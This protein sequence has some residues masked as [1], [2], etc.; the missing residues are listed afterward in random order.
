MSRKPRDCL[1]DNGAADVL[2][3]R[4]LLLRWKPRACPQL[5]RPNT[6][7]QLGEQLVRQR[8]NPAAFFS[9]A[10]AG[11]L[12]RDPNSTCHTNLRKLR[13]RINI[14]DARHPALGQRERGSMRSARTSR[15]TIS[16]DTKMIFD[17][18]GC[19][20]SPLFGRGSVEQALYLFFCGSPWSTGRSQI[21]DHASSARLVTDESVEVACRMRHAA[22][23]MSV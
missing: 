23:G 5:S 17:P 4:D 6:C 1:S 22:I 19:R 21:F 8:T 20:Q 11:R 13:I 10:A 16:D 14:E 7:F 12:L 2:G 15:Q 18:A 3:E 9:E